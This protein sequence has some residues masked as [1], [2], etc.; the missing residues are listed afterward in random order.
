MGGVPIDA[1]FVVQSVLDVWV[2]V[3]WIGVDL[4][5][6]LSGFLVSGLLFREYGRLGE[7]HVGR[8]LVRRG[9]RIYPAFYVFLL[10]T[11][12]A[13]GTLGTR[14]FLAEATFVQNYV[15]G[16]W[17]HTWSLAVEE[18]FYLL[19]ALLVMV[20]VRRGAASSDAIPDGSR[21]TRDP[22]GALVPLCGIVATVELLLRIA[23]ARYG[24]PYFAHHL[25]PTHLRLDSLLFGVVLAYLA[26]SRGDAFAAQVRARRSHLLL[27]SVLCLAPA[28]FLPVINPVMETIGFTLLYLGF[29]AVLVL[30]MASGS[31]RRGGIHAARSD[32]YAPR[33]ITAYDGASRAGGINDAPWRAGGMNAT[34]TVLASLRS[35]VAVAL[36]SALAWIGVYSYSIYLWHLAVKQWAVPVIVRWLGWQ[37]GG[38]A[39]FI[40]YVAASLLVGALMARLVEIPTLALRERWIPTTAASSQRPAAGEQHVGSV[41]A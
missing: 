38:I 21:R 15:P 40:V 22:F 10:S 26:W 8:F 9:L 34:P 36:G 23:T 28:C 16:L 5:F 11:S 18:H 17:D 7:V 4:F 35:V 19:L 3:G 2:R 31:Q 37:T 33:P 39:A 14:R 32:G 41:A 6:V 30:A 29:G 20:L 12:I 13:A 1:P 24:R 25:Y 27:V